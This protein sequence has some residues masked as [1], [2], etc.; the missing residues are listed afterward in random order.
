MNTVLPIEERFWS[1][2]DQSGDCWLWAAYRNSRGYGMFM[3]SA[4]SPLQNTKSTRPHLAHRIAWQLT[5][6][7]IPN[8]L[9]VCHHC[10]NPPCV[11]PDHLFLGTQSDNMVDSARKGRHARYNARKTH[12]T[13][14]H[15]YAG[16]NLYIGHGG[17]RVCREC[18][19]EYLRKRRE[20]EHASRPPRIQRLCSEDGCGATHFSRGWCNK[21]YTRWR[22]HGSPT[23][24]LRGTDQM[25]MTQ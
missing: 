12:C 15:K 23:I 10:D 7:T 8:G 2:V 11:R 13:R 25:E 5:Y 19:R 22:R 3:V 9:V 16:D 24:I 21:H 20:R 6:G 18:S 1:K 14:G 17:R 4:G